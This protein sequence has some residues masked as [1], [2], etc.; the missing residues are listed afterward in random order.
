M[1]GQK[2]IKLNFIILQT[3]QVELCYSVMR[4]TEYIVSL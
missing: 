3:Q 4:R 1:H 2:N